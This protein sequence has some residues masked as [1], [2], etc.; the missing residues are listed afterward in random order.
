M[1][2]V[3]RNDPCPC[4]SGVKYK[5][6]C[7]HKDQDE[8]NSQDE[9]T[10]DESPEPSPFDSA[11]SDESSSSSSPAMEAW[12]AFEAS[13]Y[14]ERRALIEDMTGDPERMDGE[15]AFHMFNEIAPETFKHGD[16]DWL[17][18]VLTR[19]DEE[20]P[21]TYAA[22]R[23]YLLSRH[24][25][26]AAVAGRVDEVAA[27]RTEDL[28]TV[29]V[30]TIDEFYPCLELI[31]YHGS[32]VPIAEAMD[33]ALEGVRES[34]NIMPFGKQNFADRAVPYAVLAY[35]EQHGTVDLQDPALRD[36]LD[37]ID[38]PEW[39]EVDFAF[40]KQFAV[41]LNGPTDRSW[42]ENDDL[43]DNIH[44][45]TVTFM[46]TLHEE[47]DIPLGR[48][49]LARTTIEECLTSRHERFGPMEPS[50]L[51]RPEQQDVRPQLSEIGGFSSSEPHRR[52]AF[53]S[54]LPAWTTFLEDQGLVNAAEVDTTHDNLRPLRSQ[55]VDTLQQSSPDPTLVRD[56]EAAWG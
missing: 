51:L 48:A 41:R 36:L 44:R 35:Y 11:T 4:G 30:K 43:A 22:E 47:T 14:E 6:C 13:D 2:E 38:D 25:E 31:A 3:G 39:G 32:L 52:A 17:I 28:A 23:A 7:L 18:H 16:A 26:A 9:K 33:N 54:L 10:Q 19:L 45:L 12:D 50:R 56:V 37:R 34:S 42:R 5:Y 20:Q 8:P 24:L 27:E 53:F 21:E 46:D 29:A 40:L 15:N 55:V 49:H 1:R